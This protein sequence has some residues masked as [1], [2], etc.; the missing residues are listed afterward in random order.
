MNGRQPVAVYRT[1][2]VD[3]TIQFVHFLFPAHDKTIFFLKKKK[4]KKIPQKQ[5]VPNT[6]RAAQG[7]QQCTLEAPAHGAYQEFLSQV[8]ELHFIPS[9]A[10]K[11]EVGPELAGQDICCLGRKK[12][13]WWILLESGRF[14]A[15]T[16]QPVLHCW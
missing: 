4:G 9:T 16:S 14:R 11:F 13:F 15:L 7:P 1:S 8:Q 5:A 10:S 6:W 2:I 12:V 3:G